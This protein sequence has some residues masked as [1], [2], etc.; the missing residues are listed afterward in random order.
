MYYTCEVV[1]ME[2]LERELGQILIVK[3]RHMRVSEKDMAH[4]IK[5]MSGEMI[6]YGP[7]YVL[8]A[9]D[10]YHFNDA[11]K[12]RLLFE[13]RVQEE[14][15]TKSMKWAV[16]IHFPVSEYELQSIAHDTTNPKLT[17]M[18]RHSQVFWTTKDEPILFDSP[19]EAIKYAV[20]QMSTL[21][22]AKYS[23]SLVRV[24]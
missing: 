16:V 24:R 15:F 22:P 11:V 8:F 5:Q 2:R 13:Y 23:F 4:Q 14:I 17:L 19:A 3:M 1:W 18:V 20:I 6:R 12:R 7:E 9:I 21:P 10:R